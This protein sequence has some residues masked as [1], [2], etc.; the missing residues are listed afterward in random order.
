MEKISLTTNEIGTMWTQHVQNSL[1][2]QILRYF[3]HTVED[4]DT[5]NLLNEALALSISI[6]QNIRTIF[7]HEGIPVPNAFKDSDV[8][9][10]A[11]K[12]F[13]DPFMIQFLEQTLKA[14]LL[15]HGTSLM[16]SVRRDIREYFTG[17][18]NNSIQLFNK[19][20]DLALQKGLLIRPP[21]LTVQ[22]DVEFVESKKYMS[23]FSNRP[24]NTIELTHLFE[25]IKTNTVGVMISMAFA[26][27]TDNEEVKKYMKRGVKISQKHVRL[28]GK[29]MEDSFIDAPMGPN[30]YVTNSTNR[31][32]SDKLMM[33][34]MSVLSAAG[35]GN[36]S[37]ASTASL[38]YDLTLTYQRLSAEIGLYAKDGADIMVKH[39]WLEEPPQAPDR[40]NLF[41][42]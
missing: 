35:Q 34:F 20:M 33:H 12:L 30:S 37:T 40:K 36:Y 7:Q 18:L 8:N 1:Y 41:H 4:E 25:N 5:L 6:E 11:E 31:V 17:T 26:Q 32:F 27:T 24:L 29:T 28:F 38:R 42:S 21:S 14:G 16:T 13:E 23:M 10:D 39:G 19:C 22:P 9:L 2:V 15:A 3:T